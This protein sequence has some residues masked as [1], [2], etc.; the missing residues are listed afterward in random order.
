MSLLDQ[1]E[2]GPLP[3]WVR[4]A[5]GSSDVEWEPGRLRFTVDGASGAQ[6]ANAEIGDYRHSARERL[7]WR[8]PVRISGRPR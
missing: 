6:L 4:L 8:P 5:V 2:A 7:P 1:F 3:Y